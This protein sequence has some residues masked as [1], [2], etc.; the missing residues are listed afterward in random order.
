M[1]KVVGK[2]GGIVEIYG[3]STEVNDPKYNFG[4][5]SGSVFV[6]IDTGDILMYEE[7]FDA[8]GKSIGGVWHP[9]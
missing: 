5:E 6:C 1:A 8:D 3:M 9:W 4:I 7:K 2:G